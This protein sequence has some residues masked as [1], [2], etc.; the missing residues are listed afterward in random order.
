VNRY[1]EEFRDLVR[2]KVDILFGN[3]AEIKALY[4][5]E[6]F[7]EALEATRK[8]AKIAALTRSEKGSVV[9]KGSET[10]AVP[11]ARV[12]KIVDTT[13][14]GDLYAS[15]FLFGLTQGKTLA[16]CARLGGIAAAEVISHVGARPEQALRG[17]I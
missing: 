7:E 13:G 14:A 4:E 5:V 15:G 10:Y 9:I 8:D 2:N 12:G 6:T 11:A 3:E 17:L 16:E 1:R